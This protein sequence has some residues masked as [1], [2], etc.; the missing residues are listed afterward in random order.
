MQLGLRAAGGLLLLYLAWSAFAAWRRPP[1]ATAAAERG[2]PRTLFQAVA[3]NLVNPNPYLGWALVLGPAA[4]AAWRESPSHAAALLVSFYGTMVALLAA[5]IVLFGSAH[6]LGPRVERALLALS[7]AAL[8]A[9]G[10]YQLAVSLPL[11][12]AF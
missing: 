7:A 2:A 9:L 12:V 11:L 10:I 3:V 6:R 5:F 1:V 4:G 8:A